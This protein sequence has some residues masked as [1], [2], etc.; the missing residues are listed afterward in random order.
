MGKEGLAA[1]QEAARKKPV[2]GQRLGRY[3]LIERI[4]A[5]GM[6]EVFLARLVGYQKLV[7]IKRILPHFALQEDF[8]EMFTDEARIA[9]TLDHPN[10]VQTFEVGVEE[11]HCYM[12]M[13]Y[14]PGEDLRSIFGRVARRGERIPVEHAL[15]VVKCVAAGLHYVHEKHDFEGRA[16]NIVHRDVNPQNVFVT[17]DVGVKLLDFGVAK[18]ENRLVKTRTGMVKGK[19]AYMSPEQCR[20]QPLDRKSDV[21]SLG[22]VLY[23]LTVGVRLFGGDGNFDV[24]KQVVEGWVPWPHDFV[25]DYDPALEKLVMRALER[26]PAARHASARALEAAI[27]EY[28]HERRLRCSQLALSEWMQSVFSDRA[29]AWQR[30]SA[31]PEAGV[32]GAHVKSKRE[33]RKA[34]V[35]AG[36]RRQRTEVRRADAPTDKLDLRSRLGRRWLAALAMLLAVLASAGLAW[37]LAG[38]PTPAAPLAPEPVATAPLAHPP[39]PVAVVAP[40]PEA[41]LVPPPRKSVVKRPPRKPERVTAVTPPP[42]APPEAP[43][44]APVGDGTLVLASSPWCHV[45]VDGVSHGTT[46]VTL[47]LKAGTHTVVVS[48]PEFRVHRTLSVEV[49]EGRT[50]RK[51][52]EFVP[53]QD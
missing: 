30:V 41:P 25:P 15:H 4:G 45:S 51:M 44:P 42:A 1:L 11:S 3:E 36:D 53:E 28:A 49:Q 29:S 50:L 26:D 20:A 7:V 47:K 12:A 48:N 27:E 37:R 2:A 8:I 38:A 5:G 19:V 31:S 24:M 33:E 35:A 46:P 16:L 22:I 13:E 23:E 9:T 14:L 34:D 43:P 18:A 6:A 39:A 52:L 21:F 32:I 10:V 17:Y 40:P